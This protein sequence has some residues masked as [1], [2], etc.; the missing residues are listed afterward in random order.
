MSRNR[1]TETT[2]YADHDQI[3]SM[4]EV[5]MN[6]NDASASSKYRW[7]EVPVQST[8]NAVPNSRPKRDFR[9][10]VIEVPN[11]P[12][13]FVWPSRNRGSAED[14]DE[15]HN[16]EAKTLAEQ[17]TYSQ[18]SLF[19]P[20]PS[21]ATQNGYGAIRRSVI[22]QS[23]RKQD[24]EVPCRTASEPANR[25]LSLKKEKAVTE[26]IATLSNTFKIISIDKK[27]E[28]FDATDDE[29]ESCA[30]AGE[31]SDNTER[32]QFA[33]KSCDSP[34]ILFEQRQCI[35]EEEQRWTSDVVPPRESHATALRRD[36][37]CLLAGVGESVASAAPPA[38]KPLRL[39][40]LPFCIG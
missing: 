7:T 16:Q 19:V 33:D 1:W 40:R 27:W 14:V 36:R 32:R 21:T 20:S 24:Q 6:N 30:T 23:K 10:Q 17:N 38:L 25:R 3:A 2:Y 35:E 13:W 34:A 22:R 39:N 4:M 18:S 9:F 29:D 37:R 12:K 26:P 28:S 15:N 5:C 8:A 11:G 31:L